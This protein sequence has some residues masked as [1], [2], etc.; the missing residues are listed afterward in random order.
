MTKGRTH[1]SGS[2]Q[3]VRRRISHGG[4][5]NRRPHR[6]GSI[7]GRQGIRAVPQRHER[8]EL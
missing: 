4:R 2:R 6:M 7:A 1:E 3:R 5:R 8:G